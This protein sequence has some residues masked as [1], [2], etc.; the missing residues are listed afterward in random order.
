MR[1][2]IFRC[3]EFAENCYVAYDEETLDAVII[4]P[5][6]RFS[7]EWEHVKGFISDKQLK[8]RYILLTHFHIDHV[9]GTDLCHKEYGAEVC[10]SLMDMQRLPSIQQMAMAFGFSDVAT[11]APITKNLEEGDTI[12]CGK[13]KIRVINCP[14]HSHA[15]LCYYVEDSHDIFTGDVLFYCSVGRSD[16]GSNLGCDGQLLVEGIRS[17]LLTL[18]EETT[19]H[20]GHGPRTSIGFEIKNNPYIK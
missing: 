19:V 10:G 8:V 18:P 15:G 4:D 20:P 13:S 1:I 14:G 5:G 3:N 17:K 6:I 9:F 16:L 11:I 7:E 2:K 12:E